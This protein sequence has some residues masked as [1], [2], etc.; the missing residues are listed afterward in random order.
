[1]FIVAKNTNNSYGYQSVYCNYTIFIGGAMSKDQVTE[2]K[3]I[4]Y[5]YVDIMQST[6]GAPRVA[7]FN[8]FLAWVA[9]LK[10]ENEANYLPIANINAF[11]MARHFPDFSETEQFKSITKHADP[12]TLQTLK[13]AYSEVAEVGSKAI[14]L[15]T[16]EPI[17]QQAF[18]FYNEHVQEIAM[19][20]NHN[21]DH[22]EPLHQA[23]AN[24]PA[25][26]L[27]QTPANDPAEPLHQAPAFVHDE[28]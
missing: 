10:I 24:N 16:L 18:S 22:A 20:Q 3:D 13:T 8:G 6:M 27:H 15:A 7:Q 19:P 28:V 1:M 17:Y 26:P 9:N 25:E 5:S 21:H 14:A 2:L 12:V 11:N 23:P 4:M